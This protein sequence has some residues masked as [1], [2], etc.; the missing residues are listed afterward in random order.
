MELTV[1]VDMLEKVKSYQKIANQ[2]FANKFHKQNPQE[3]LDADWFLEA[4]KNVEDTKEKILRA[5]DSNFYKGEDYR[6]PI[7]SSLKTSFSQDKGLGTRRTNYIE[8]LKQTGQYSSIDIAKMQDSA[9]PFNTEKYNHESLTQSEQGALKQFQY[10]KDIL[11]SYRDQLKLQA[12]SNTATEEQI[13]KYIKMSN[14]VFKMNNLKKLDEKDLAA[15]EDAKIELNKEYNNQIKLAQEG[16]E[17]ILGAQE[18]TEEGLEEEKKAR[19]DILDTQYQQLES[20][21]KYGEA[22]RGGTTILNVLLQG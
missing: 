6:L 11:T 7:A 14:I 18:Y 21:K 9:V 5:F 20:A 13:Q 10:R 3:Q 2:L 4:K 22:I 15:I 1:L 19:I 12:T 17:G 8:N 16:Y